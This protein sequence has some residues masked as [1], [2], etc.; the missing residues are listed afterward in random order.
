MAERKE[1]GMS[2][3]AEPRIA[4]TVAEAQVGD[5]LWVD[6]DRWRKSEWVLWP[7]QKVGRTYLYVGIGRDEWAWVKL[8]R[9]RPYDA[10]RT[11]AGWHDRAMREWQ[12]M[13]RQVA[14]RFRECADVETLKT[15]AFALGLQGPPDFRTA[16]N[17]P[18]HA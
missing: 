8:H 4:R 15:V 13:D 7:A 5:L 17:E 14:T 16:P 11:V 10:N 6:T 1:A 2:S 12:A 3:A 9:D 18:P